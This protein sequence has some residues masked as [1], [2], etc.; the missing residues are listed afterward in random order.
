MH[1]GPQHLQWEGLSSSPEQDCDSG[2]VTVVRDRPETGSLCMPIVAP[3]AYVVT[4]AWNRGREE[5]N[6]YG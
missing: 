5:N 4:G 3:D 6:S 1:A 2:C